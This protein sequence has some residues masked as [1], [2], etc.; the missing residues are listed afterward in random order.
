LGCRERERSSEH[1]LARAIFEKKREG[2]GK[3]GQ[4]RRTRGIAL[5]KFPRAWELEKSVIPSQ[6]NKKGGGGKRKRRRGGKSGKDF[7]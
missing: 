7:F 4:V 2:K 3:K 1:P 5:P 6:K